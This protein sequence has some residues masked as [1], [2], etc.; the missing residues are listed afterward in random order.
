MIVVCMRCARPH[1]AGLHGAGNR[2]PAV[3]GTPAQ[4]FSLSEAEAKVVLWSCLS[5]LT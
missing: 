4:I 1:G 3:G 2:G 5:P